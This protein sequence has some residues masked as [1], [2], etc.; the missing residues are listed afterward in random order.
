MEKWSETG[1]MQPAEKIIKSLFGVELAAR[2][3]QYGIWALGSGA[4]EKAVTADHKLIAYCWG[5]QTS[6]F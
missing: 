1:K 4:E 3:I 2:Q 5:R 6:S